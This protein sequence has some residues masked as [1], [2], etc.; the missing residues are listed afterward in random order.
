MIKK[1][2]KNAFLLAIIASLLGL[3]AKN[4]VSA[5]QV[6]TVVRTQYV[7]HW[8]MGAGSKTTYTYTEVRFHKYYKRRAET[9]RKDYGIN[10]AF[11][12]TYYY[13]PH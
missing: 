10:P 9:V 13:T 2:K 1:L 3:G 12:T 4:I 8:V 6:A 5:I 11:L 7:I